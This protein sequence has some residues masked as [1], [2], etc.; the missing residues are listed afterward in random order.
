MLQTS[1]LRAQFF[2][3]LLKTAEW[4]SP[5]DSPLT[6]IK[7]TNILLALR[8]MVN[9]LQEGVKADEPWLGQVRGLEHCAKYLVLNTRTDITD[10]PRTV[11]L[12]VKN[13]TG[14]V[15]FVAFQVSYVIQTI[16]GIS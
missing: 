7:E 3:A 4:F 5:W 8:T 9:A 13:S 12:N 15:S 10:I 11:F 6:K 2:N 16:T 14:S 1:A